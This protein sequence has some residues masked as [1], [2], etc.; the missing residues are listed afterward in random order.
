MSEVTL[1]PAQT[2]LVQDTLTTTFGHILQRIDGIL[3]EVPYNT[4]GY[5]QWIVQPNAFAAIRS[6]LQKAYKAVALVATEI[7][8]TEVEEA[9]EDKTGL[10]IF[11]L[12]NK[13]PELEHAA[14][15]AYQYKG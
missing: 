8:S 3:P 6:E 4:E 9:F 5:A 7:P 13:H 15:Q 11:N 14:I 2:R 1:T 12:G 10:A